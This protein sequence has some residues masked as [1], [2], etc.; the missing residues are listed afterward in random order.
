MGRYGKLIMKRNIETRFRI[1]YGIDMI[2]LN[3]KN[4]KKDKPNYILSFL[5]SF[6]NST[7]FTKRNTFVSES[8]KL[9]TF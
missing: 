9:N 3:I 8:L 2:S 1:L 4:I 5:S 7:L 6:L